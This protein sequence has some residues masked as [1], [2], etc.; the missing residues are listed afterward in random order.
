MSI[1][2]NE[3]LSQEAIDAL[4]EKFDDSA[5]GGLT[6]PSSLESTA[7]E[8]GSADAAA[9][10]AKQAADDS[11]SLFAQSIQAADAKQ[12]ER[13]AIADAN[14]RV[15]EN[16]ILPDVRQQDVQRQFTF[17]DLQ[18]QRP[19]RG[20]TLT[21]PET[22]ILSDIIFTERR[23]EEEMAKIIAHNAEA[24]RQGLPPKSGGV[25][26]A[27]KK[28]GAR[29]EARGFSEH[30]CDVAQLAL[31]ELCGN[32]SMYSTTADEGIA[33]RLEARYFED[34]DAVVIMS[35]NG[36]SRPTQKT[37]DDTRSSQTRGRGLALI[38]GFVGE[39]NLGKLRVYY[40]PEGGAQQE[41]NEPRHIK[42]VERFYTNRG[43]S[44]AGLGR[45]AVYVVVSRNLAPPTNYE[46]VFDNVE[47]L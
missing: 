28:I 40:S 4:L 19:F 6:P 12:R 46:T 18:L 36:S 9:A 7:P 14:D 27:R 22:L 8:A 21:Q 11:L 35:I 30:A 25:S 29:L 44:I 5:F 45:T 31:S 2:N 20:F 16:V 47:S 3:R 1:M 24:E 15:E 42:G 39:E 37:G 23:R 33:G 10:A 43:A 26:A 38:R 32:T 41:I 17:A 34:Q 13:A